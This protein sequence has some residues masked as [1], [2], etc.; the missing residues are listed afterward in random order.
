[1]P[2]YWFFMLGAPGETIETVRETLQF[3]EEY[4]PPSHMVLFSTGIRVYAGTPLEQTCKQMGWFTEDES[5]FWPSWF[6]SPEIELEDL[7][8]TLVRAARSHPNWMTNA[9]TILSPALARLMK[10]AFRVMGWKGPFWLHLPK[11]FKLATR[12]GLRQRGLAAVQE[13]LRRM[14]DVPHHH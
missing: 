7:Y 6:L 13:T 9:E 14:A 5:L 4:I 8:A 3:C 2:T 11:L 12:I 1:V 10:R